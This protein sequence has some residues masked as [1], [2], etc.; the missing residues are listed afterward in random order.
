MIEL[1]QNPGFPLKARQTL[2]ITG[3]RHRQNLDGNLAFELRIQR[4]IDFPYAAAAN[5]GVNPVRAAVSPE[6]KR[7]LLRSNHR[8]SGRFSFFVNPG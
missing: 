2:G 3:E 4:P 7:M 5:Q 1:D 8:I 6:D